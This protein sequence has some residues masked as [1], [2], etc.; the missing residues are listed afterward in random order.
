MPDAGDDAVRVTDTVGRVLG[1]EARTGKNLIQPGVMILVRSK[2]EQVGYLH[3]NKIVVALDSQAYPIQTTVP[4]N[5]Y[6]CTISNIHRT[7]PVIALGE[8]VGKKRFL[9]TIDLRITFDYDQPL[10]G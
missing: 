9:H 7:S 3:A 10:F 1:R 4:D 8:E 6:V 5:G 2:V